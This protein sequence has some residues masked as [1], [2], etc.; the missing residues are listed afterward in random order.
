[1]GSASGRTPS[2]IRIRTTPARMFPK[3]R[4]ASD[5]SRT[6]YSIMLKGSIMGNG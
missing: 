5:E 1:M 4:S 3:S 2:I 6:P